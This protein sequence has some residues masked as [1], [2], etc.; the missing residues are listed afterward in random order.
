VPFDFQAALDQLG[1]VADTPEYRQPDSPQSRSAACMLFRLQSLP[2]ADRYVLLRSWTLPAKGTASNPGQQNPVRKNAIRHFAGL[3]P[4]APPPAVFLSERLPAYDDPL[5]STFALLVEA[6]RETGKLEE[7]VSELEPL[8]QRNAPAAEFS[9]EGRLLWLLVQLERQ[10][11]GKVSAQG[12][13]ANQTPPSLDEFDQALSVMRERAHRVK[14]PRTPDRCTVEPFEYGLVAKAAI[15]SPQTRDRGRDLQLVLVLQ[16][17]AYA[18]FGMIVWL[19]RIGGLGAIAAT[20]GATLRPSADPGLKHWIPVDVATAANVNIFGST[21]WWVATG[22]RIGHVSSPWVDHLVFAYPLTGSFRIECETFNSWW[23]EANVAYAGLVFEPWNQAADNQVFPFNAHEVVHGPN[24]R[25][26]RELFHPVTIDVEPDLLRV[27]GMEQTLAED[28]SP[29]PTSPFFALRT[30]WLS[31]FRNLRIT[32]DPVI[33]REVRLVDGDRM[34][35]WVSS[36]YNESQPPSLT[37][38]QPIPNRPGAVVT[39]S[40]DPNAYDWSAAEGGLRG[41]RVANPATIPRE[42]GYRH[43]ESWIYYHRPLREG[44][45]VRYEFFYQPGEEAIEIHPTLDRLA[46]LMRPDGVQLHWITTNRAAEEA[47][48]WLPTDNR[49][50]EPACRRGP[51]PLPL[52]AGDWNAASIEIRGGAVR[53]ELNGVLVYERP[54]EKGW[55]TRFGLYHDRLKSSSRI[56]NV[57][58]SGDWPEWSPE[59]A[60]TLLERTRPLA[61]ADEKAIRAILTPRLA[62]E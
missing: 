7:L 60:N 4:D 52:I 58:L 55:G 21:S 41:R 54:V 20:E 22:D 40:E 46:F 62:D 39:R 27:R 23:S 11:P 38:G 42:T 53:L 57:R 48:D 25:D 15:R 45:R 12:G 59:L 29:S 47:G 19:N 3:L 2:A 18:N 14:F 37:L 8:V 33:P 10:V 16:A 24:P 50:E 28:P 31:A 49:A 30:T 17:K 56:R 32:G 9:L 61:P 1:Q 5:M 36:F 44:D 26:F 51:V 6:A 34:E 43:G 13:G 35:G